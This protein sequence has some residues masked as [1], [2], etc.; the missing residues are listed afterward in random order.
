MATEMEN[1]QRA[2]DVKIERVRDAEKWN[3]RLQKEN[4]FLEIE[5]ASM[6]KEIEFLR[7]WGVEKCDAEMKKRGMI[8]E[9]WPT[10][11]L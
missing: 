7:E 11:G 6:R 1:L 8:S 3:S 9:F 10:T 2:L 4:H 5:K